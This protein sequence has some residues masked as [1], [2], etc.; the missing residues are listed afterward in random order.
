MD[1]RGFRQAD[2]EDRR[3]LPE[4]F[5][6]VPMEGGYLA[7][8]GSGPLQQQLNAQAAGLG[9]GLPTGPQAPTGYYPNRGPLLPPVATAPGGDPD[10]RRGGP[11]AAPAPDVYNYLRQIYG[12]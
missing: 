3:T 1:T 8:L 5:R 4:R 11:E 6:Y 9:S 10:Y 12:R 7:A 2:I